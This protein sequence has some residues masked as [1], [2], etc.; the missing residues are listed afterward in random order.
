MLSGDEISKHTTK[1]S[2]WIVIN[3]NAYDVTDVSAH[4]LVCG[5]CEVADT[6]GAAVLASTPWRQQDHSQIRR[7]GRDVRV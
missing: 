7:H 2:C 5:V 6:H 3:G 1:D 4:E